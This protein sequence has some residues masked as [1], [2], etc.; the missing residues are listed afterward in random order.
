MVKTEFPIITDV[1]PIQ[2]DIADI[3]MD[4]TESGIVIDVSFSQP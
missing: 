3:P 2:M 1:N 4:V